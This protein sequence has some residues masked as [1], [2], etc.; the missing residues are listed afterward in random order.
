ML[1]KLLVVRRAQRYSSYVFTVY[2]AFHITN[3]SI[4][5]LLTR[6]VPEASRFLLLTRPYYQSWPLAEPFIIIFPLLTHIVSGTLLRLNR[7]RLALQRAGAESQSDRRTVAWPKLSGTSALGYLAI[8]L[9]IG[10]ASLT[11][12]LPWWIEGGSSGIGLDFIGHGVALHK[13]FGYAGYAALVATMGWHFIFGW[14]KWLGLAPEQVT[15]L[16]HEGK[17]AS[18]RRWWIINCLSAATAVLWMAG[19]IGVVARNGKVGGWLG[20]TYDELY[21]RVPILGHLV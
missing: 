7:R 6:S 2:A 10:H 9:V 5:P 11:R 4:L 21:S 17:L 14:S 20:K 16:G 15:N 13:V 3:T 19:G 18:Q 12:I 8:P 1:L